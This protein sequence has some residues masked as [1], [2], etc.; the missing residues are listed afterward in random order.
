LRLVKREFATSVICNDNEKGQGVDG[1]LSFLGCWWSGR[2]R[3]ERSIMRGPLM[4]FE[5]LFVTKESL[6]RKQE[7]VIGGLLLY[8]VLHL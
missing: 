5:A 4:S 7:N 3:M 6:N 1:D 8:S 2:D